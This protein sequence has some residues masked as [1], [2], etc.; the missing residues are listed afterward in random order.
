M[1]FSFF[2]RKRFAQWNFG[3]N[4]I[5]TY[6]KHTKHTKA[7]CLVVATFRHDLLVCVEM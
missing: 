7:I 1:K 2:S 4:L 3:G 6:E 5:S